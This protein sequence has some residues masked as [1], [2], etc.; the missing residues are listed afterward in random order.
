MSHLVQLTVVVFLFHTKPISKNTVHIFSKSSWEKQNKIRSWLRTLLPSCSAPELSVH[1]MLLAQK[2][3]AN[4]LEAGKLLL[5]TL[6]AHR[7]FS[8]SSPK[9]ALCST[10]IPIPTQAGHRLLLPN[11]KPAEGANTGFA[12]K[13]QRALI[14][15]IVL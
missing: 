13:S 3:N 5:F 12:G 8:P 6:S 11:A 15:V 9:P 7:I 10:S 2:Q 14:A 4:S 1:L